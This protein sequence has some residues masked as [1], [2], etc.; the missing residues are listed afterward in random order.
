[1]DRRDAFPCKENP[2]K[3]STVDMIEKMFESFPSLPH[4][5]KSHPCYQLIPKA[6]DKTRKLCYIYAMRNHKDT[7]V[8]F[9]SPLS[10]HSRFK[11][12]AFLGSVL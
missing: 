1:M 10:L 5:F 12:S 11:R 4:V 3:V 8:S 7:A 2:Y 6:P 9:L